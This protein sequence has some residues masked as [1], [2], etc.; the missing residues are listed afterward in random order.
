MM[1][2]LFSN[3]DKIQ[4]EIKGTSTILLALD[5]DGTLTPIVSRPEDAKLPN[6]VKETLSSLAKS[7]KFKV[8]ILSG[9][10]LKEIV[11]LIK[12]KNIYYAGNHGFE[13]KGPKVLF[14]HP[15]YVRFQPYI[16]K[17]KQLLEEQLK[18]VKGIIVEDKGLTLSL[19]YRLVAPAKVLKVKKIFEN[20]IS[21]YLKRSIVR[22]TSGKKVFEVRPFVEWNKGKALEMIEK[23]MKLRK[24]CLKIYIGDDITDEDAFNVLQQK[25]ISIFVGEKKKSKARYFLHNTKEVGNFLSRLNN[26]QC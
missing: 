24:N 23:L 21:D 18:S 22:V 6:E 9:R 10:R 26:L 1:Q 20:I 2:H 25:D 14:K 7:D 17:I 8:A 15:S 3:W 11:G 13:I 12:I 4:K 19:H 16:E 5:Y